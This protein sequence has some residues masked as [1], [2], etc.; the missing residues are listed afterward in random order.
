MYE[1]IDCVCSKGRG[2]EKKKKQRNEKEK[3]IKF[4]FFFLTRGQE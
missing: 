3:I 1:S 4:F 2:L